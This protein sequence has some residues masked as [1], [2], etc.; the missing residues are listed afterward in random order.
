MSRLPIPGQ[1]HGSWGT[2]LNDYLLAAHKDDGTLKDNTVSSSQIQDGAVTAAAIAPNTIT[3][4]VLAPVVTAKL[5]AA[6][7]QQGATGPIGPQGATGASGASG[8]PGSVGATGITGSQGLQGIQGPPGATGVQG[9]QGFTGSQGIQG[10]QG[11]PGA[12]GATGIQGPA[13]ATTISGIS[14]LQTALDSKQSADITLTGLASLD[15]STGVIVQTGADTF[16]KRTLTGTVNQVII[17]NGSGQN[18]NPTLGLSDTISIGTSIDLGHVSDTTVTRLSAGKIA[19]ENKEIV[20]VSDTQ[21]LSNKRLQPMVSSVSS[22]TTLT[23]DATIAKAFYVT[24]QATSLNLAT[25][26]SMLAGETLIIVISD[27]GSPQTITTNSSYKWSSEQVTPSTTLVGHK[28]EIIVHFDGS[29]YL[30]SYAEY[31]V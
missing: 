7:G 20:T 14:G 1:D 21:S 8:I 26:T 15:S 5:N 23:P 24:S 17:A 11:T 29:N 13:G 16:T 27:N 22:T 28:T 12:T 9:L 2:I 18:D 31:A 25:P 4:A 3:E 19:V 10:I 6:T 30:T